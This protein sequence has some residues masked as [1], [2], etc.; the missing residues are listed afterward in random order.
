MYSARTASAASLRSVS[1]MK[2]KSLP[3]IRKYPMNSG[4][5]SLK[6]KSSLCFSI[7]GEKRVGSVACSWYEPKSRDMIPSLT[8]RWLKWP[9]G[10]NMRSMVSSKPFARAPTWKWGFFTLYFYREEFFTLYFYREEFFSS[11][12]H[13]SINQSIDCLFEC[14]ILIKSVEMTFQFYRWKCVVLFF[15]DSSLKKILYRIFS[16]EKY[17]FFSHQR[18]QMSFW[19]FGQSINQSCVWKALFL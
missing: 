17:S 3:N 7:C 5:S 4:W 8:E 2:L 14:F 10:P 1:V 16:I 18:Q 9:E 11:F 6:L 12:I 19:F 15:T 13:Q